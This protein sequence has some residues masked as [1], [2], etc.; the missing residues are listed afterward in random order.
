[1][2][3]R[4]YVAYA[5]AGQS[6]RTIEETKNKILSHYCMEESLDRLQTLRSSNDDRAKDD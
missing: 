2:L 5:I 6:D 4:L 1:M 3:S